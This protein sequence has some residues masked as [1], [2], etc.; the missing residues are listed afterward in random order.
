MAWG[1]ARA[2]ENVLEKEP[3]CTLAL[4]D[5]FA[6]NDNNK[7]EDVY[8]Y[9]EFMFIY[10]NEV[11]AIYKQDNGLI[12]PVKVFNNNIEMIINNN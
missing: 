2:I 5:K 10:N 1:H 4:S 8:N 7:L 9:P 6:K 12:K 11:L 3:K